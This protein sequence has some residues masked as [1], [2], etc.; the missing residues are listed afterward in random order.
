[1]YIV[2]KKGNGATRISKQ[3]IINVVLVVLGA[4]GQVTEAGACRRPIAD[5]KATLDRK[6]NCDKG[7]TGI[8]A[9]CRSVV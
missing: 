7:P 2:Q 8:P 6:T 4:G 9:A 1:M 3:K 5:K